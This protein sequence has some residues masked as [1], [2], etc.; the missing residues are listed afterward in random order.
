MT[1]IHPSKLLGTPWTACVPQD[2]EKHFVV[3][4]VIRSR[5][6]VLLEAVASGRRFEVDWRELRDSAI[7][8]AGWG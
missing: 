4:E 3:K 8:R 7:W 2:R 6:K 1:S 5:R